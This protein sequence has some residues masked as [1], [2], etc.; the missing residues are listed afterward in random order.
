VKAPIELDTVVARLTAPRIEDR[1]ASAREA[2]AEL[3]RILK[4]APSL[5]N[6]ERG[7]R[8]RIANVMERLYP[9]E[10]ARSRAELGRLL[11]VARNVE[12]TM[13]IAAPAPSPLP[14]ATDESLFPGTRY[15]ILRE[16]GRGAMGVVYEAHHVDLGRVV[17]LKVLPR[18]RCHSPELEARFRREARSI[19]RL[20]HPNLVQLHDSGISSDGR[21][22]YAMEL[23]EGETLEQY[24]GRERGM[25][26][27][28]AARCGVELCGALEAAHAAGLVHRDIKPGNVFL[29]KDNKIKLL[30]FGVVQVAPE[31]VEPDPEALSVIGTVEY[32]APEQ[33]AGETVDERADLYALGAVLYELVTGR[34]PHVAPTPV[35]LID[36][37]LRA[38]PETP[39]ERAPGR[40]IP[41]ALD[42]AIMR[43][44]ARFPAQRPKNAAELR[45]ALEAALLSPTRSRT[46]RRRVAATVMVACAAL[47]GAAVAKNAQRPE[48]RA[49]A[50]ALAGPTLVRLW[51]KATHAPAQ[52]APSVVEDPPVAV[53]YEAPKPAA[54]G[55]VTAPVDGETDETP[56]PTSPEAHPAHAEPHAAPANPVLPQDADLGSELAR[57]DAFM[58]KSEYTQALAAYR[59]LGKDHADDARVLKGWS[60][61]AVKTKG[62][63]EALRVAVRWASSDSSPEAQLYLAKIQRSAGQRYGAV[64]TLTR[65]IEQHPEVH[66][67]RDML[68]RISDRKLASR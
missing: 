10:P 22:Y 35:A 62:W 51:D 56:D 27:R 68:D 63:G 5:A 21:P 40:G 1:F 11:A 49:R 9:A 41:V 23:L 52:A 33:A 59:A 66:E 13:D 20:R 46:M 65:L 47:L 16:L 19:A 29:T 32:M 64:A 26:W 38:L 53:L 18:E 55:V 44:L 54:E 37:K 2:G 48:V 30:D 34:L 12:P 4:K 58:K 45:T 39:R 60:E 24:L 3:V 6:G 43:A 61:A 36:R 57:A 31:E 67:A 17:A 50:A 25:D 7:V 8:A 14:A 28:E 15:R 42:R